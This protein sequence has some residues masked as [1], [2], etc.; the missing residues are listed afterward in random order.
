MIIPLEVRE[1]LRAHVDQRIGDMYK[2]TANNEI[3]R[4][5]FYEG[6]RLG[7]LEAWLRQQEEPEET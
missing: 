7:R 1:A 6:R 2:K 4:E 3:A 5:S